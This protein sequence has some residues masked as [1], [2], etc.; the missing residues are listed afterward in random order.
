[1][2]GSIGLKRLIGLAVAGLMAALAATAHAGSEW[3]TEGSRAEGLDSCVIDDTEKMRRNHMDYLVHQRDD[4]VRRGGRGSQYK[5][6]ECVNCH[7]AEDAAG[8]A[9]PI[10]DEGQFCASCH[11]YM[12]VNVNCF[13]CHRKVPEEE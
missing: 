1:M 12:A 4:V 5:L 7:T 2:L 10:D 3:V 9:I 6:A 8:H 13:Q 11:N